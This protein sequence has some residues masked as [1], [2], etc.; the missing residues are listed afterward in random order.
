MFPF[1]PVFYKRFYPSGFPTKILYVNFLCLINA[2]FTAKIILLLSI[3]QIMIGEGY[4]SFSS[5]LYS[6]LHSH[7]TSSLLESHMFLN[8]I[9]LKTIDYV[10]PAV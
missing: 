5:S 3:T 1:K 9:F 7:D 8:T 2:T 10:S 4:R 6:F